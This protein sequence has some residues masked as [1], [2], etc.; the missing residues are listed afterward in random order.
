MILLLHWWSYRHAKL[1]QVHWLVLKVRSVTVKM[2]E[3]WNNVSTK[4]EQVQ[5]SQSQS[6]QPHTSSGSI[7]GIYR[8]C[9]IRVLI[10]C[11]ITQFARN[12]IENN[13][14]FTLVRTITWYNSDSCQSRCAPE[15]SV[16]NAQQR[17]NFPNIDIFI[18]SFSVGT[19]FNC[20]NGSS[21]PPR[22][23]HDFRLSGRETKQ[24]PRF[25]RFAVII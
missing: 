25:A 5:Q 16:G 14:N 20:N 18:I 24:Q 10:N 8:L 13:T 15:F 3:M 6:Q 4:L 22:F 2:F 11:A 19:Y 1:Q 9:K 12:P 17:L 23:S 7:K 21:P